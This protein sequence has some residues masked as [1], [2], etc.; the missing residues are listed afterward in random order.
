MGERRGLVD[1]AEAQR[2]GG[3]RFESC[4]Q[5]FLCMEKRKIKIAKKFVTP[6]D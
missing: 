2:L 4:T 1:N 6:A 3:L 5:I